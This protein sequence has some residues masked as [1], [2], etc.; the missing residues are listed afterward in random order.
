MKIRAISERF[1]FNTK[2]LNKKKSLKHKY[3]IQSILTNL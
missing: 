1:F 3:V 2:I